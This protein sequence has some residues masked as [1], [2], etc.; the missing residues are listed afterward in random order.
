[1][2][3]IQHYCNV[4]D[5][6]NPSPACKEEV[7]TMTKRKNIHIS[8]RGAAM[9]TAVAAVL[10][11][12][13]I[14]VGYK[15]LA[16]KAPAAETSM[17][18]TSELAEQTEAISAMPEYVS[19]MQQ[20]YA[21]QTGNP[22]DFDFT[23]WG[24]DINQ[25]F[26]NEEYRVTLKAVTG[27]DWVLYCFYDIE[28]LNSSQ[29]E[30]PNSSDWELYPC[31]ADN[32]V[33]DC[34]SISNP[35]IADPSGSGIWHQ[36]VIFSS[37]NDTPFSAEGIAL[38]FME[39]A[40]MKKAAP[41]FSLPLDFLQK[42]PLEYTED[43]ALQATDD[44][45][46][47]SEHPNRLNR[48]AVTP[49]GQ[50]FF[51]E[52]YD[53]PC[54][55]S[56]WTCYSMREPDCEIGGADE[57][58]SVWNA[59]GKEVDHLWYA[60]DSCYGT[61]NHIG[62][63]IGF[64]H[65][66]F[67][68]PY[69]ASIGSLDYPDI[70]QDTQ[71]VSESAE[72]QSIAADKRALLIGCAVPQNEMTEAQQEAYRIAEEFCKNTWVFCGENGDEK[73]SGDGTVTLVGTDDSLNLYAQIADPAALGLPNFEYKI[74]VMLD[75]DTI[76]ESEG[77]KSREEYAYPGDMDISEI[78]EF[79]DYGSKIWLPVNLTDVT[80]SDH[81]LTVKVSYQPDVEGNDLWFDTVFVFI[82]N[83]AE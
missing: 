34:N 26:E 60:K 22:C 46:W 6:M 33:A 20:Y 13:N 55:G 58:I 71:D 3:K 41:D 14:G 18:A 59:E 83:N 66:L 74:D 7:I 77:P 31:I 38:R 62:R 73:I 12:V 44:D 40:S 61:T 5:R 25:T 43:C 10:L 80:G 72:D 63:E 15:L 30:V 23:G 51:S 24:K 39:T 67:D 9:G 8:R 56:K 57:G 70:A 19:L 64:I 75:L 35:P 17:V 69:D 29:T 36:C 4:A 42:A 81:K 79:P 52:P 50:F 78:P 37:S 48:T 1:M 16:G 47:D 2:K 49:F 11:A 82:V 45:L 54:E 68:H 76:Y 27:C 53:N 28:P 21:E 32:R 65:I